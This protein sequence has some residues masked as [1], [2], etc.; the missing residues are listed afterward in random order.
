MGMCSSPITPKKEKNPHYSKTLC[1]THTHRPTSRR[2][3]R[4]PF[5]SFTFSVIFWSSHSGRPS[6]SKVLHRASGKCRGLPS[7]GGSRRPARKIPGRKTTNIRAENGQRTMRLFVCVSKLDESSFLYKYW[8][9]N[10]SS[11][12]FPFNPVKQ[13]LSIP[14]R[15]YQFIRRRKRNK[16]PVFL[17]WFQMKSDCSTRTVYLIT[18]SMSPI[19]SNWKKKRKNGQQFSDLSTVLLFVPRKGQ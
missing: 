16:K 19:V 18:D 11:S 17:E 10:I 9:G 14:P 7:R 13:G 8:V 15:L 12:L 4:K 5:P 2:R 6:V 1:H 3:R